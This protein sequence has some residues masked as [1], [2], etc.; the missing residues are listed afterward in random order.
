MLKCNDAFNLHTFYLGYTSF[1]SLEHGF[2]T[3]L[4]DDACRG[5]DTT[6]IE[7]TKR[8]LTSLGGVVVHS[9]KVWGVVY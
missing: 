9:S 5:V 3:I 7:K 8:D 1:H 6:A 4:I 2:K